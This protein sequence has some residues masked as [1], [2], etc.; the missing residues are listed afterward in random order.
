MVRETLQESLRRRGREALA[1]SLSA[2]QSIP[3]DSTL[4]KHTM[5]VNAML[6]SQEDSLAHTKKIQYQIWP[7]IHRI[8]LAS[9]GVLYVLE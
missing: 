1:A 4:E 3:S 2:I 9:F 8:T 6:H 5:K 7:E